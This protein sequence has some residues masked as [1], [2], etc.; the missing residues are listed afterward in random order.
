MV[1]TPIRSTAKMA[2]FLVMS[3]QA[4]NVYWLTEALPAGR[5][6][7]HVISLGAL[8]PLQSRNKAGLRYATVKTN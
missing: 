7:I 8:N 1:E 6:S 5:Y 2:V 4:E 3:K